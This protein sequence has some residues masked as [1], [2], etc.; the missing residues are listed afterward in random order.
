MKGQLNDSQGHGAL[1]QI[2][3]TLHNEL[4]IQEAYHD[5]KEKMAWTST[6]AFLGFT[7]VLM[8]RLITLKK[9][10]LPVLFNCRIDSVEWAMFALLTVIFILTI[11]FMSMQFKARWYSAGV[12]ETVYKHLFKLELGIEKPLANLQWPILTVKG[13]I[14]PDEMQEEIDQHKDE[15]TLCAILKAIPFLFSRKTKEAL[16]SEI[17]SYGIALVMYISQILIVFWLN[18]N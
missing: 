3:T 2:L 14:Y 7:I 10:D 9:K 5:H 11:A 18:Y 6:Y 13:Q 15:R 1:E 8:G 12:T 4:R 16:K 17:P